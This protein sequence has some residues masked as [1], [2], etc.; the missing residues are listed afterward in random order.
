[1][2]YPYDN[3]EQRSRDFELTF[4]CL[5]GPRSKK[6]NW[7]YGDAHIEVTS[8]I[9]YLG[10]IFTANGSFHQAQLQLARQA[11]KSLFTFYKNTGKYVGLAPAVILGLFDKLISPILNY[12]SEVWGFHKAPDIE[13]VH[14][15]FCKKLLG[16]KTSAQ[17]DFVY[18]ELGRYPMLNIRMFRIIKY[19]IGIVQAGK[20]Y[21][22][23][24]CYQNSLNEL[25]VSNATGSIRS[26]KDML[27]RLGFGE[28]WFSQG[29]GDVNSFL[30]LFKSRI[31]DISQ[32]DW[33]NRLENSSRA[34]FY[35]VIKDMPSFSKYIEIVHIKSHRHALSRLITSSH[36]LRIESGRWEQPVIPRERRHCYFCPNVVEDEY[37]F[38][39]ECSIY[40]DLR[41]QLIPRYFRVRPS[42]W[43]LTQLFKSTNRRHI[44]GLSKFAYKAFIQRNE[45]ISIL[46]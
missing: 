43:K 3:I 7:T 30:K 19:W 14:L 24:V 28:V 26:V 23:N 25:D 21:W 5:F 16:V 18:G 10:T 35:R 33:H 1:M 37:H 9:P 27:F 15:K 38:V 13:R 31:N 45:R 44:L 46:A 39:F 32:Q 8:K 42:M 17:N 20:S 22:V 36:P 34:S 6:E 4:V 12:A 2:P 41:T 11:N 40:N 29:V